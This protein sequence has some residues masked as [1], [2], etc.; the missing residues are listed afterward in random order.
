ML[1]KN[2]VNEICSMCFR[3][4]C[5]NKHTEQ[6]K[7]DHSCFVA[8]GCATCSLTSMCV[9]PEKVK[10]FLSL[11]LDSLKIRRFPLVLWNQLATP[12]LKHL[13]VATKALWNSSWTC[14][15]RRLPVALMDIIPSSKVSNIKSQSEFWLW[16]FWF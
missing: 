1:Q 6:A 13:I 8:S 15:I 14:R 10:P 16:F 12:A 9:N 2:Y 3:M 5:I 7:P 4:H 11:P